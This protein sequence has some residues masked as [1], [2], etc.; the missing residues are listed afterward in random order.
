[1][2]QHAVPVVPVCTHLSTLSNPRRG[3]GVTRVQLGRASCV[4]SRQ[5]DE[6]WRG[7]PQRRLHPQ[8]FIVVDQIY[9]PVDQIY[10]P[11]KSQNRKEEVGCGEN[12]GESELASIVVLGGREGSV[13]LFVRW[14]RHLC[15]SLAGGLDAVRNVGEDIFGCGVPQHPRCVDAHQ[16]SKQ[17][18]HPAGAGRQRDYRFPCHAIFPPGRRH[19]VGA[20]GYS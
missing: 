1:M 19:T 20:H 16:R 8:R 18:E 2:D 15:A 3:G 4:L 11:G 12:D 5:G 14:V 6:R 10:R 7:W 13:P 9:R 17:S